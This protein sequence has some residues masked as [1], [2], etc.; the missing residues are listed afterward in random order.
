MY[1]V[2]DIPSA[3]RLRERGRTA[4]AL[5]GVH[6]S[7]DVIEEIAEV[8]RRSGSPII[9]ALDRDAVSNAFDIRDRLFHRT[10]GKVIVAVLK[11]VD[12]KNMNHEELADWVSAG[13]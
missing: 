5:M 10:D 4:C 3:E 13:F 11:D 9:I 8:A 2:E 1:I 7:D 12:I 6:A